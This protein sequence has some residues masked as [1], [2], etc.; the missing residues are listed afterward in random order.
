M[1]LK[2]TNDYIV[3]LEKTS[4]DHTDTFSWNLKYLLKISIWCW[5]ITHSKCKHAAGGTIGKVIRIQPML[6]F[7]WC[8]SSSVDHECLQQ[9]LGQFI[10]L[11]LRYFHLGQG[12]EPIVNPRAAGMTENIILELNIACLYFSEKHTQNIYS[13]IHQKPLTAIRFT[14]SPLPSPSLASPSLNLLSWAKFLT[15]PPKSQWQAGH[16]SIMFYVFPIA[17]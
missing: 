5:G 2:T 9:L 14:Q 17:V 10:Q 11:A 15:Q 3:M 12:S 6:F 7:F 8:F 1:L 16:T 4:R 13:D